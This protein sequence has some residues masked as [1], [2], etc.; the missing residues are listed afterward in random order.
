M[1][2]GGLVQTS[3]AKGRLREVGT[4]SGPGRRSWS[5]HGRRGVG[6][7][8]RPSSS[9]VRG[10]GLRRAGPSRRG[11][12]RVGALGVRQ[13]ARDRTVKPGPRGRLGW[14]AGPTSG[15]RMLRRKAAGSSVPG[16]RGR[17][18]GHP[19]PGEGPVP[20]P[21]PRRPSG[22]SL[23]PGRRRPLHPFPDGNAFG[24]GPPPPRRGWGWGGGGVTPAAPPRRTGGGPGRRAGVRVEWSR[25]RGPSTV[26]QAARWRAVPLGPYPQPRAPGGPTT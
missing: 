14:S 23:A 24:K 1:A 25:A 13:I 4:G 5:F 16:G 6:G 19:S 2:W 8:G 7:G 11:V 22:P 15:P 18:T 12:R 21:A 17:L 3:T 20:G 26:R 10:P 9:R